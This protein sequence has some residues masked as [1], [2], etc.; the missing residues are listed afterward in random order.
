VLTALHLL[1]VAL[2]HFSSA[3]HFSLMSGQDYPLKDPQTINAFFARNDC[4]IMHHMPLVQEGWKYGGIK[5]INRFYWARNRKSLPGY[6]FRT[7][8]LPPRRFPIPLDKVHV[9][10]CWWALKRD[11]AIK[12]LK[13]VEEKP[14]ILR[15]FRWTYIPDE[16]FFSTVLVGYLGETNLRNERM[17][18]LEGFGLPRDFLRLKILNR[19]GYRIFGV[20]DYEKLRAAPTL[21]ARKFDINVDSK[22]MDLLDETIAPVN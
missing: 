5:R 16:M 14:G 11:D 9:G 19:N 1:R 13:F 10:S 15:A 4:T 8:P 17:H 21:F 7:I 20:S 3:S 2:K 12:I 18:Y 6:F 22:V